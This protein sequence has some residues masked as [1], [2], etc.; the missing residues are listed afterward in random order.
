M[1]NY[2]T[3]FLLTVFLGLAVSAYPDGNDSQPNATKSNLGVSF[4]ELGVFKH[5]VDNPLYAE[6]FIYS[7]S[8]NRADLKKIINRYKKRYSKLAA[9]QIFIFN[10]RNKGRIGG[11]WLSGA[12]DMS[13][14]TYSSEI[15]H[16][17]RNSGKDEYIPGPAKGWD[18]K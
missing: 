7:P 15:V 14:E 3:L 12:D 13:D 2:L 8:T 18:S 10:D 17:I 5:P 4:E 1:Q 6:V 16:Y 11:L 9:F